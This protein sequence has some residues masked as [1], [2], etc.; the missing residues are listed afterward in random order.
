MQNFKIIA[1][2]IVTLLQRGGGGNPLCKRRCNRWYCQNDGKNVG[3]NSTQSQTNS[4][5]H[6]NKSVRKFLTSKGAILLEFAVAIPIL[7]VLLYYVHDLPKYARMKERME[8]CAHCAVNMIQNN[9]RRVT[10]QDCTN[11]CCAALIPYFGGGTGQYST[12]Q[13]ALARGYSSTMALYYL[14]GTGTNT[15]RIIWYVGQDG[16]GERRSFWRVTSGSVNSWSKFAY[17]LQLNTDYPTTLLNEGLTINN[18]E[19][20]IVL[21]ISLYIDTKF[22]MPDGS[23]I[24]I[25]PS[26]FG[27]LLLN[28]IVEHQCER[29]SGRYQYGFFCTTV[30][31]TPKQGLFSEISP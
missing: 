7:I 22:I 3:K 30:I 27:F 5:A 11:I 4:S 26:L 23:P 2:K 17:G 31:F 15:A 18:G 20:K 16:L 1:S 8:F 12:T 25:T 9:G 19:V 21:Y 10:I 29:G 13:G 6:S 28:P 14:M 24:K